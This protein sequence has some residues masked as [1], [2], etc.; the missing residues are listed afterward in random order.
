MH[1]FARLGIMK[2]KDISH[3]LE[4]MYVNNVKPTDQFLKSICASL[5]RKKWKLF[6]VEYKVKDEILAGKIDA[7]FETKHGQLIIVDWKCTNHLLARKCLTQENFQH[8]D[9]TYKKHQ[10]QLSFY[11]YLLAK[12]PTLSGKKMHLY[13]GNI[14]KNQCIL[15]KCKAFSQKFIHRCIRKYILNG[16]RANDIILPLYLN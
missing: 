9:N 16:H 12:N 15:F 4:T 3:Y 5:T 1:T 7:I 13:V 2:H 8:M 6:K 14:Y 10:L 11:K